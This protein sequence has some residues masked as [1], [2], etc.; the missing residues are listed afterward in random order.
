MVV[1][2]RIRLMGVVRA[3]PRPALRATPWSAGVALFHLKRS[4][5]VAQR[6]KHEDV[7]DG[8]CLLEQQQQRNS[9]KQVRAILPQTS[10]S[11]ATPKFANGFQTA[12]A[13]AKKQY[14]PRSRAALHRA[15][16]RSLL[17]ANSNQDGRA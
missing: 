5:T 1:V 4:P 3:M 7:H 14:S 12:A 10:K 16:V 11:V 2:L 9:S 8:E 13:I 15:R 17:E 6:S